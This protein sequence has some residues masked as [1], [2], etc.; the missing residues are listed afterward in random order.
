[1]EEIYAS[2]TF[3]NNSFGF[4]CI[5]ICCIPADELHT[6]QCEVG[7]THTHTHTHTHIRL[8]NSQNKKGKLQANLFTHGGVFSLFI[9][10]ESHSDGVAFSHSLL[11]SIFSSH[12]T[13]YPLS[14]QY[15]TF[16]M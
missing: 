10:M 16:I 4:S 6:T 2:I 14:M 3:S 9:L 5:P 7:T 1:M 13:A 12:Y 8:L 15:Q 11:L